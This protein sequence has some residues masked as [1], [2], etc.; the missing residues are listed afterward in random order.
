MGPTTIQGMFVNI[1][2][3]NCSV[4]VRC[5]LSLYPY[6]YHLCDYV[7]TCIMV[8]IEIRKY[9]YICVCEG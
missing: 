2:C 3:G 6:V 4:E 1:L 5:E 8:I 9:K 7:N